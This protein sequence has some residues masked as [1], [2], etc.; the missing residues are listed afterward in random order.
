M[1]NSELIGEFH[2]MNWSKKKVLVTGAGGFIGSFLV[3]RLIEL[4]ADVRCFVRYTSRNQWGYLEHFP[5]RLRESFEV[6]PGDLCNPEAVCS[7]VKGVDIVFHLGCLISVQYSF[8][9]PREV[10]DTNVLGTYNVM[11]GCREAEVERVI[12]TS[13]SEVYGTAQEVPISEKHS[14][15]GQSP[16]SASKIGADKLVESFY[17]AYALP[18]VTLRPFNAYGPRQSGRAVVPTIITQALSSKEIYL[19][20]MRP[21]RDF[22]FVE[23]TADA[24]IKVAET[25]GILGEV[26]NVGAGKEISI[27][28]LANY[29]LKVMGVEASVVF[30]ATRI[31][32]ELS[33]VERLCADTAK[34]KQLLKWH[35]KVSLK[36]GIRR[37][38]EWFSEH[39]QF[40]KPSLYNI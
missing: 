9:H 6:V 15:R 16:Y 39:L 36:E 1:I 37:T 23:D 29:I 35:P 19:G 8:V 27:G 40:Y 13:S 2:R 11:Q 38:V 17:H 32:P 14:L 10:F 28:D 18:V 12:H 5:A 31:R 22:T 21:T 7:A 26:I 3:E 33:E 4:G 30:D 34:A 24:F 25:P 20:S